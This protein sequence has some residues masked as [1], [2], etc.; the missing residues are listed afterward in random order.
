MPK[1]RDRDRPIT[2]VCIWPGYDFDL[3]GTDVCYILAFFREPV[4][5]AVPAP[6]EDG[7]E[8]IPG[9]KL[10]RI[11][12]KKT[13]AGYTIL[14]F[15]PGHELEYVGK[16][17]GLDGEFV[18]FHQPGKGG[19]HGKYVRYVF[20][21]R[22]MSDDLPTTWFYTNHAGS[23]RIVETTDVIRKEIIR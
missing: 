14:T 7:F 22:I 3:I 8:I 2:K 21:Y 16:H 18:C 11:G 17:I 6:L 12:G 15:D 10:L 1:K 5:R 9:D 4:F 13:S 23:G 19:P 20:A